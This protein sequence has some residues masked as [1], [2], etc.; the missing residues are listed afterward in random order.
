MSSI[1]VQNK[2][3]ATEFQSEV[4]EFITSLK[5]YKK[6]VVFF[7]PLRLRCREYPC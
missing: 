4:P 7:R 2:F 3:K 1:T 5:Y 6:Q